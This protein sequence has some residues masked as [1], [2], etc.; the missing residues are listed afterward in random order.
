MNSNQDLLIELGCEELPPKSLEKLINA[1][2]DIF[3]KELDRL[4]LKYQEIIKFASPRRLATVIRGLSTQQNDK[5]IERKGPSLQSA[6]SE[7]GKPTRAAIGFAKSCGVEVAELSTEEGKKGSWLVYRSNVKGSTFEVLLPEILNTINRQLPIP[8]RMKW[9]DNSVEFVRPVKWL[10]ILFGNDLIKLNWLGLDSSNKTFGHRFH[11]PQSIVV[12]NPRHYSEYL[13]NQGKVI[14]CLNRRK[15]KILEQIKLLEDSLKGQA[16]IE[17]GL[18][19][20][21]TA[22]VEWPVA[23][24]GSFDASF[25]NIPEEVLISTMMEKQKYFPIRNKE[26]ALMNRF[27]TISNIESS[28]TAVVIKGNEKVIT[29]RLKDAQFFWEKDKQ[30]RLEERIDD[31]KK[32][33]F[34]NKLGSLYEKSIRISLLGTYIAKQMN[35][36][37]DL[38]ERTAMLAK[39]DLLTDMVSEFP[40]L[41]GIMGKHYSRYDNEHEHVCIGIEEHYLPRFSADKLPEHAIGQVV[42][43]ADRIDTIVANFSVGHEPTGDKDPYG[44]RRATFGVIRIIIEKKIRLNLKNIIELSLN[45]FTMIENI[46]ELEAKIVNYFIERMRQYFLEKQIKS[47]VIESVLKYYNSEPLDCYNRILAVNDFLKEPEAKS[48]SA[49]NKRIVNMLKKSKKFQDGEKVNE[50]LLIENEERQLAARITIIESEINPLLHQLNYSAA[51]KLLSTLEK[52]VD[53]FFEK[54]MVMAED[55]N[56]QMNRILLLQKL[57][58]LFLRVADI[59][60]L[61]T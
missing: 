4:D 18:I 5:S 54:I 19:N 13:E 40:D 38:V 42:S 7:D 58:L 23:I 31:L 24:V 55:K 11:H 25:L 43:I 57:R 12:D 10:M 9:G 1:F 6:F 45:Q 22:L 59:S 46:S 52:D 37:I 41:Q 51:L 50:L 28:N 20:E 36:K 29:P 3:A 49:A 34:Q 56:V 2:S 39:S 21:V 27:I 15:K 33:V 35:I 30:R 26:G 48:L 16:I 44:L 17:N 32:V 53:L 8:K 61:V 47:D 14:P 60:G